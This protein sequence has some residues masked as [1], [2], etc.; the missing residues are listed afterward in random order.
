MRPDVGGSEGTVD[1]KGQEKPGSDVGT[2]ETRW[3]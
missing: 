2:R 3:G 1:G